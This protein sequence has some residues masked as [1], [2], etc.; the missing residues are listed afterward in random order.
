[1]GERWLI[2][3]IMKCSRPM[4]RSISRSVVSFTEGAFAGEA[5]AVVVVVVVAAGT[6]V[7]SAPGTSSF[8]AA[9][10]F[11]KSCANIM[12]ESRP[13]VSSVRNVRINTSFKFIPLIEM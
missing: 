11:V 9:E 1:M 6:A 10:G 8:N 12:V 2:D 7:V 3:S 4:M 13:R 5:W